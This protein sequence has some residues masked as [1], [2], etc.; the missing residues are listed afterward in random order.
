MKTNIALLAA[1]TMLASAWPVGATLTISSTPDPTATYAG[2]VRYR[3]L[4]SNWEVA[5]GTPVNVGANVIPPAQFAYL[6]SYSGLDAV[7]YGYNPNNPN[8]ETTVSGTTTPPVNLQYDLGVQPLVNY[9]QIYLKNGSA[10][11]NIEYNNVT[12]TVGTTVY[13]LG[14]FGSPSA[15]NSYYISGVDLTSGFT[16]EGTLL[17]TGTFSTSSETDKLEI[18]LGSV[19]VPEPTTMI[20]GALLLLPFGASMLRKMRKVRAA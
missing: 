10:S 11:A 15:N 17:R 3:N 6:N 18:S 14:N 19:A 13:T 9:L 1:A 2:R 20:A 12:L 7:S 5:L 8:E 4:N 16:L